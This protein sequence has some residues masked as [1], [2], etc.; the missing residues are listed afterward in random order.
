MEKIAEKISENRKR[1]EERISG[2]DDILLRPMML[3]KERETECFLIYI[4]T[5]VSNLMLEDSVIGRFLN[6]LRELEQAKL[7][8]ILKKDALGISD[9]GK[10]F[11]TE[12][13]L[14]AMLAGNAV[15]F[16]DG[17]DFA[18]KFGSKG[19]PGSG[20]QKA[21][22]EKVLRGSR[23]AFSESEKMNTALIR[24]RIRNTSLKVEE[25]PLG[26]ISHTMTAIL[27]LE[28]IVYPPFLQAIRKKL[29][30]IQ[31]DGILDSGML[32]QL[33]E[34]VWYSPFPQY[35]VTERPDR[36]AQALLDG[37]VVVVTDNS[38][39]ALILPATWNTLFQTSDDTYRHFAIVSFLRLIRYAAAFLALALPGLY[40]AVTTLHPGILPTNLLLA[41]K[42]AREDVP[43]PSLLEV[44]LLELAFELLREAGL[45]MPGP[46]G[47]TIGIVGGLIIG[48]AAVSASLV[49]PMVVVVVALTALGDFAIP[50]EELS[51]AIRLVKYLMLFLCAWFGILGFFL[52]LVFLLAHL[53]GLKSFGVSYL[54][55]YSAWKLNRG[56]DRKDSLVR[57][58]LILLKRRPLFARADRRVRSGKER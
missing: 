58:P 42:N 55:P 41:L 37:R 7:Y 14:A 10:L 44:L 48:Q 8:E 18:L 34:E 40:V 53:A 24:K 26:E 54:A 17:L 43:F 51:E 50:S 28:E 52:G 30:G 21:E 38:P 31:R 23:E 4:E 35:Q 11:D 9:T 3:G 20:V 16:V 36:A 5:A 12:A 15:L 39:E 32:E 13:A 29:H 6:E 1:I 47:S 33:T 2:C 57:F 22:S 27:Y 49:S 19:Y 25:L 56:A 46:V 45:R